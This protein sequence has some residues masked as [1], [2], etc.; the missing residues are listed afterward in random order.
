[1]ALNKH[2]LKKSLITISCYIISVAW[3]VFLCKESPSDMC[4]PG[5]GFLALMFFMVVSIVL[6][7][8]SLIKAIRINKSNFII[9]F[10]HVIGFFSTFLFIKHL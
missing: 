3:I 2:L 7:I 4:N 6:F 5:L 9:T 10:I 1:M 8:A